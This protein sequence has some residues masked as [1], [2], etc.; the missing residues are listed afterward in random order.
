M[1]IDIILTGV[2]GVAVAYAY[3][4]VKKMAANE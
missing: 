2:F 4:V 1:L 3:V